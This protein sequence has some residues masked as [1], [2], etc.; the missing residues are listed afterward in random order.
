M[1]CADFLRVDWPRFCH[2]GVWCSVYYNG[3]ITYL[4]FNWNCLK[5][6]NVKFIVYFDWP[7]TTKPIVYIPK[8]TYFCAKINKDEM[9]FQRALLWELDLPRQRAAAKRRG[10]CRHRRISPT[11]GCCRSRCGA[12]RSCCSHDACWHANTL[13]RAAV[14][15]ACARRTSCRWPQ[16]RCSASLAKPMAEKLPLRR[17]SRLNCRQE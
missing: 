3:F 14:T 17:H 11:H 10:R 9:D 1:S 12:G 2:P 5:Q 4:S 7:S 6:R 8:S 13:Q 15:A 16:R